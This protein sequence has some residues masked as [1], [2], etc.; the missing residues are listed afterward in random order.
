MAGLKKLDNDKTRK[1]MKKYCYKFRKTL[2]FSKGDCSIA[3]K[4]I[5]PS[6]WKGQY[7]FFKFMFSKAIINA[8][9][10]C[11]SKKFKWAGGRCKEF[12]QVGE[13][14]GKLVTKFGYPQFGQ[15]V[16]KGA[17]IARKTGCKVLSSFGKWIKK[18]NSLRKTFKKFGLKI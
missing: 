11:D 14:G 3:V 4:M 12:C 1:A 8:A 18:F 9:K 10:R 17:K 7:E 15:P 2:K 13:L 6:F 5:F 16:T